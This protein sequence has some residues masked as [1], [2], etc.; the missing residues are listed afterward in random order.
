MPH[1]TSGG[2]TPDHFR[3]VKSQAHQH[4]VD[5]LEH[6]RTVRSMVAEQHQDFCRL[7]PLHAY[8]ICVHGIFKAAVCTMYVQFNARSETI[9]D[10][11]VFSSLL[12][13]RRCVFLCNGWYEWLKQVCLRRGAQM[14]RLTCV[15]RSACQLLSA[16]CMSCARTPTC[17]LC[18]A[19]F[20]KI[21]AVFKD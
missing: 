1:S 8:H 17:F 9:A 11:F 6:L 10:K 13:R 15:L 21:A 16:Q 14:R 20:F 7:G 4:A 18:L 3:M 12:K 5:C 2:A 19:P